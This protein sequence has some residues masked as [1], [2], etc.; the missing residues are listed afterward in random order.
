VH[1]RFRISVPEVTVDLLAWV[2]SVK[3]LFTLI[4]WS[5]PLVAFPASWFVRLGMPE[6]KPVLFLRLLGAAYLA[7]VVGYISGLRRLGR[8][9]EV[10]DIVWVGITSNGSAFLILLLFGI[11]G[12]WRGWGILARIYMS[13]SVVGTASITLGLVVAGLWL[14]P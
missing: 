7:L 13:V 10:R 2:L 3:I 5:F 6:P 1:Q 14:C 8:G 11:A 9:D 12:A 4:F